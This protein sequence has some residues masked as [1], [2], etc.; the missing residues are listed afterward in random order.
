P[1]RIGWSF[2]SP[3]IDV[4]WGLN[5]LRIAAPTAFDEAIA[6]ADET[7]ADLP[8][9]RI[10][11]EP[12][13]I[14]PA[15]EAAFTAAGWKIERDLLMV[16]AWDPDREIDTSCV[17]DVEQTDHLKLGRL[18]SREEAPGISDDVLDAL[19]E[20]WRREAEARGDRLLGVL[21][22]DR[23]RVLAKAKLRSDGEIA[24]V[25]D[26]Y[27]VAEARGRGLGRALVTR[28]VQLAQSERHELIFIVAD[29]DDWPKRLYAQIG[30]EP[31]GR[32]VHFHREAP[33]SPPVP[34]ALSRRRTALPSA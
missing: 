31:V 33:T 30:F 17:T 5:H 7:Q 9:R 27:T 26:V 24:Q 34:D 22:P 18:W 1:L 2:V 14:S 20:F 29:E 8:Y 19:V 10:T 23:K 6:L 12:A 16:H 15:L 28:A 25:E 3:S 11:V 4:A 32:I 13:A 21:D